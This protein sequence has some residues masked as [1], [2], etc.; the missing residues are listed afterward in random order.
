MRRLVV[1]FAV[2][3]TACGGGEP[4]T[5]T[6][7][8][9]G[10]AERAEVVY[11]DDEG[12]TR[13]LTVSLPWF[14]QIEFPPGSHELSLRVQ[15]LGRTGT[16]SCSVTPTASVAFPSRGITGGAVAIC[17]GV[18]E[19]DGAS[20]YLSRFDA[21][22]GDYTQGSIGDP[23]VRQVTED[24][25]TSSVIEIPFE[26]FPEDAIIGLTWDVGADHRSEIMGQV[27]DSAST[28]LR[29]RHDE[30]P[31]GT[32]PVAIQTTIN[33]RDG[34]AV[35]RT[36]VVEITVP[37]LPLIETT[38]VEGRFSLGL[39]ETWFEARNDA[40][41]P[42]VLLYTDHE[43][44]WHGDPDLFEPL[45]RTSTGFGGTLSVF[46]DPA[47]ATLPADLPTWFE[48]FVD[49]DTISETTLGGVRALQGTPFPAGANDEPETR[50][51]FGL[52]SGD[53]YYVLLV[54]LDPGAADVLSDGVERMLDSIRFASEAEPPIPTYREI[55]FYDLPLGEQTILKVPAP[56]GWD[57]RFVD[58]DTPIVS[59]T[60][61]PFELVRFF[62]PDGGDSLTYAFRDRHPDD[63]LDTAVDD[64]IRGTTREPRVV[65]PFDLGPS[66]EARRIEFPAEGNEV[67]STLV[68]IS[69]GW[70]FMA[71]DTSEPFADGTHATEVLYSLIELIG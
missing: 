14:E 48:V 33:P 69:D 43:L 23:I 29:L 32:Y 9:E 62:P 10:T 36:D 44:S 26:G 28:S 16:V 2:V 49:A 25:V 22:A 54:E 59:S 39:P 58:A 12:V 37:P 13:T 11:D 20:S 46:V 67:T 60:G 45:F 35:R 8:V 64:A 4:I 21:T 63:T 34:D 50:T 5:V 24:G 55:Q 65:E 7:A 19:A 42:T 30:H 66:V 38:H 17:E 31:S 61:V 27:E 57:G 51:A 53:R 18:L 40:E 1:A 41:D 6:L 47:V 71:T 3:L 52:Q 68:G 56:V 15:N 70:V